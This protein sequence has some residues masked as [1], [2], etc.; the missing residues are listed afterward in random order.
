M[1]LSLFFLFSIILLI[2][3]CTKEHDM[4]D[5]VEEPFEPISSVQISTLLISLND[6]IPFSCI[7]NDEEYFS[8]SSGLLLIENLLLDLSGNFVLIKSEGYYDEIRYV[9]PALG[10]HL[11]M[12]VALIEIKI[13]GGINR[14]FGQFSALEGGT[15]SNFQIDIDIE[16]KSIVDG[17]GNL[18]EG[19]VGVF[20][21][22]TFA[23]AYV[24]NIRL[25]PHNFFMEDDNTKILNIGG[26]LNMVLLDDSNNRLYLKEDSNAKISFE[27][28]S[29]D[30]AGLPEIVELMNYDIKTN[31]W[32]S[33]GTAEKEGEKWHGTM[34]DFGIIVWGV[35]YES[36]IAEIKLITNDGYPVPNKFVWL[37]TNLGTPT[38]LVFSDG[39]GIIRTHIPLGVEFRLSTIENVTTPIVITKQ[40]SI[41]GSGVSDLLKLDDFILTSD[42]YKIYSGSVIDC[43]AEIIKESA[44]I[45]PG[46]AELGQSRYN[47][48]VFSDDVGVFNFAYPINSSNTLNFKG[49]DLNTYDTSDDYIISNENENAVDFGNLLVCE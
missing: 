25:F 3:S 27:L 44:I 19:D 1:R 7:I 18:F 2:V 45:T 8:E 49:F 48:Y 47:S 14:K 36:R 28:Q 11:Y 23:G 42:G 4:I 16:P 40:Y 35:K 20:A 37:F 9:V 29:V 46:P 15:I 38:S 5:I 21:T 26:G 6:D 10:A 33:M 12:E 43:N 24:S 41:V 31:M 22:N 17:F 34:N 32:M 39:E 30:Q 13:L